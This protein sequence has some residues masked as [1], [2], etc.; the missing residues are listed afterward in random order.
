MI[1]WVV[2]RR[3]GDGE[4]FPWRIC[5]TRAIAR[6]QATFYTTADRRHRIRKYERLA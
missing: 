3:D 2:E 1:A 5:A 6:M 4:W